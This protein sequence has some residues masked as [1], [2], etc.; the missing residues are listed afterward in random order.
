MKRPEFIAYLVS[1]IDRVV[2]EHPVRVG[3][4]GVDGVGKTMLADDL[5][6]PLENV[7]RV[8]IRSSIDGF[9]NPRSIRYRRGR[10]SPEGYFR[11]SFDHGSLVSNLLSPLGPGGDLRYR[12]AVFDYPVDSEVSSPSVTADPASVLLFD[13]VFLHRPELRSYWDVSIFLKAPFEVTARR[14]ADRDQ[15]GPGDG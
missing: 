14:L 11:D 1:Q 7:G 3:I 2:R 4:D 9:H 13:G 8:V 10:N 5:V 15:D 6:E 12:R